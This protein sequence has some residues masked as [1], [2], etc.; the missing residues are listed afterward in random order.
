[1]TD[2]RSRI[3][4]TDHLLAAPAMVAAAD[5]LGERRVRA[6]VVAAQEAA[7]RGEL[8]PEEVAG[9][10]ERQL[11]GASPASLRP[12]LN[13]TGVVVHTNLGRAPL[14]G[15]A[16][17]ALVDAAGYTDVELDL[18]TGARSK[19]GV[20]ARAALLAA[21]PAAEEALVVNNG[22]AALVLATTALAAGREVVISRG[23]LIEIGAGFRLPDLIASTGA[24]LREVGTTNRTH[25][26]DYA[27]A[28]GP[29]TGCVLKVHPSNFRVEG[30]TADVPLAEL[31]TVC[32]DVPLVMDLGSGLLAA[33]PALPGEPDAA[34]ALAAGADVVT[35]SG[36]KL[37]GGPQAGILLGR[38]E[39]VS[40]LAKHPLARAVR[41]DKL[42]L[43][44][45][46]AT[47]GGPE[48][49]VLAYLHADPEDLRRRAERLA[50]RVGG[51]VVPHDG[52][53]G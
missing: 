38:A 44:A 2:P 12:V 8:A 18:G 49:P 34:S 15:A 19:R 32:G 25:A 41:A 22:A 20:A 30:F 46:E 6:A 47:V 42:V 13:A 40:R 7:R 53:V 16:V 51:T 5:R 14:S 3:P 29:E 11:A 27:E 1:M 9:S 50:A 52:R 31:R 43:A 24:R 23:E 26:R 45:L 28:I 4:R 39:L 33:D 21:C 10:V 35:A 17:A 48:A 36:D 37:L